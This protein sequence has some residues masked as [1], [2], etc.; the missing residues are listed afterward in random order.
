VDTTIPG[1]LDDAALSAHAISAFKSIVQAFYALFA[2]SGF[3]GFLGAAAYSF[4]L[5]FFLCISFPGA[6][7]AR[8]GEPLAK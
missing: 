2:D 6:R 5:S 4:V 1:R 7:P 3:C 8:R